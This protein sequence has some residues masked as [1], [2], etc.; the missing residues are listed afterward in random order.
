MCLEQVTQKYRNRNSHPLHFWTCTCHL[1]MPYR[2]PYSTV[3]YYILTMQ[4]KENTT[5]Q[6]SGKPV[7]HISRYATGTGKQRVILHS[8]ACN[9]YCYT[10]CSIAFHFEP[11]PRFSKDFRSFPNIQVT[12]GVFH[13]IPSESIGMY[14]TLLYHTTDTIPYHTITYHTTLYCTVL[15][16]TVLHFTSLHFTSPHSTPLHSTPLNTTTWTKIWQSF[17]QL[18]VGCGK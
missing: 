11:F 5:N 1:A 10:T 15:Y 7:L 17:S 8:T 6:K 3:P 13:G 14:Y 2:I 12:R 18:I 4:F 9:G 16:C